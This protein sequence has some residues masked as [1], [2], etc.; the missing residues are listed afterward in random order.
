MPYVRMSKEM[1]VSSFLSCISTS[2]QVKLLAYIMKFAPIDNPILIDSCKS[3]AEYLDCS[4]SSVEKAFRSFVKKG[5]VK[6]IQNGV[7]EVNYDV[8]GVSVIER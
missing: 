1:F 4:T 2:V 3:I 8:I 5:F 7:W 6:K